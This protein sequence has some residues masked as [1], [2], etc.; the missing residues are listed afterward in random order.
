[1]S[2]VA[3]AQAGAQQSDLLDSRLRGNDVLYLRSRHASPGTPHLGRPIWDA[4]SGT[5]SSPSGGGRHVALSPSALPPPQGSP[6]VGLRLAVPEALVRPC[7]HRH[8]ARADEAPGF[9]EVDP[10]PL[11]VLRAAE[12]GRYGQADPLLARH[13]QE[14]TRDLLVGVGRRIAPGVAEL[15]REV[16][17]AGLFPRLAQRRL[18]RR[19]ARFDVALGEIPI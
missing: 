14:V 1:M 3:P 11:L 4:V 15:E 7:Q 13:G 16:L 8:Q 19:L 12:L 5:N 18:E 2:F 6:P 10:A 17:D 9:A